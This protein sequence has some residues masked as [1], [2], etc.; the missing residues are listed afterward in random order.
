M[1]IL[2]ID[3]RINLAAGFFGSLYRKSALGNYRLQYRRQIYAFL[4][5]F[6]AGL[7]QATLLNYFRIFSVKPDIILAVLIISSLFL[8]LGWSVSLAFFGGIFCDLMGNLP[9]GFNAILFILSIILVKRISSKLSVENIFIRNAVICLIIVL[10]NLAVRFILLALGSSLAF[11]IFL[12][13]T[14]IQ[15]ILTLLAALPIYRLLAHSF[16]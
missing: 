6:I 5:L 3:Q 7:T 15:S 13:F 14:V 10:N 11:G 2:G 9:Y 8:N 4:I 1:K 16:K 12:R